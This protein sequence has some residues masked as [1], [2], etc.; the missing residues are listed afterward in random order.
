MKKIVIA[1]CRAL[2]LSLQWHS[3]N[4]NDTLAILIMVNM[5]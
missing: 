2:G 5:K 1:L 4:K 3:Q